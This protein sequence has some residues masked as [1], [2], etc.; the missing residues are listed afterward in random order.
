M[1]PVLG[2]V[3]TLPLEQTII[4]MATN[5]INNDF[6]KLLVSIRNPISISAAAEEVNPDPG[7]DPK[8]FATICTFKESF[9]AMTDIEIKHQLDFA[10]PD[11]EYTS[12]LTSSFYD[13]QNRCREAMEKISNNEHISYEYIDRLTEYVTVTQSVWQEADSKGWLLFDILDDDD[14]DDDFFPNSSP[15]VFPPTEPEFPT[16]LTEEGVEPNP[17]PKSTDARHNRYSAPMQLTKAEKKRLKA[18]QKAYNKMMRDAARNH[19]KFSQFQADDEH[20]AQIG[21]TPISIPMCTEEGSENEDRDPQNF[22]DVCG[23]VPCACFTKKIRDSRTW[24]FLLGAATMVGLR[25][26]VTAFLELRDQIEKNTAQI[27]IFDMF[28]S[29]STSRLVN[30]LND[31]LDSIPNAEQMTTTLREKIEEVLDMNCGM[32]PISIRNVLRALLTL[33]GLYAL[34]QMGLLAY[35]TVALIAGIALAGVQGVASMISNLDDWMRGSTAQIGEAPQTEMQM[36]E[37]LSKVLPQSVAFFFSSCVVYLL[38]KVPGRDN[39][40]ESWMRKVSM[41]PRTCSSLGE[42]FNYFNETMKKA[43]SYF[44]ITVMGCDPDIVNDAIPEI[45]AWMI[46]I[47]AYMVPSNLE[48]AC[49]VKT[50]RMQIARLYLEGHGLLLKYNDALTPEYRAA[51]QRMMIQAAKIKS[52]VEGKYPEFKA[53][54]NVPLPIWLVG[55]S[56]IGKSRLQSLIATELCLNAGLEDCKDQIYQR[57]VE[58]EYW[59]GYNN[60]FVVIMDD[61]GQM[62]DTVSAPNLEFFEII[63]S[64]GPFPYPLHMADIA[65]KSSTMFTSGV[66]MMSTNAAH[67]NIESLTYPDAVWNRLNAQSW[68]VVL[69]DEYAIMKRDR[70]G[71]EYKTLNME[72]VRRDSP[73]L[74]NGDVW[75]INPYIYDFIKFDARK[76]DVREMANGQKYGWDEFIAILKS[77]LDLRAGGGVALDKFLDN[78]IVER[79]QVAQIG[80]EDIRAM[81]IPPGSPPHTLGEFLDWMKDYKDLE[82]P[83]GLRSLMYHTYSAEERIDYDGDPYTTP[84]ISYVTTMIPDDMYQMLLIAFY[85]S[86]TEFGRKVERK[87]QFCKTVCDAKI[88]SLPQSTTEFVTCMKGFCTTVMEKL[89]AFVKSDVGKIIMLVGTGMML[90]F[91]KSYIT[92]RCEDKKDEAVAESDTRN[93]QPRLRAHAKNMARARPRVIKAEMGQSL[94]QLDVISKIR[95]QQYL[96]LG[97]YEDGTTHTFGTI[98][99]I[100]GQIFL[101]PGHF[102]TYFQHRKPVEMRMMHC[103]STKVEIVKPYNEFF[104]TIVGLDGD[105]APNDALLFSIPNFIRGKSIISHFVSKD[106]ISKLYER[107]VYVTLSG[108]DYEKNGAVVSTSVSGP[109]DLLMDKVHTYD[110]ET[111]RGNIPVTACSVAAYTLPTKA[112]DC[113]KILSANCD[114]LLGRVLGIHVSGSKS[115]FNFAQIVLKEELLDAVA[116]FPAIAQCARGMNN[117][118]E[119]E[120]TPLDTGV[121]HLG[122]LPEHLPQ[123]SRTTIVPSRMHGML[124]EPTTKPAMLRPTIVKKDGEEVLWDPLVEGA[125]KAGRTCGYVATHILD[126]AARDVLNICKTNFK[127]GGPKVEKIEYEDAIKGVEGDDLFQPIN[128]TTSPGYPY[129]TQKKMRSQKGKTNWMGKDEWEFTTEEAQQ[130]KAD[131]MKMEKDAAESN[132][133]DVIWVDTLKDERRPNEKAD[134]GNTRV[135]SNG[136]MHFN[137]LFRMYFMAALAFIRHNRIFNGVAVG[138]NV[139]DREWDHLAKWL[140]ANSKRLIDGDFKNFDG[141]LM[142]QF[143]WKIFWILDSMYDDEFHTIRYNLWYQVVYAIR[144]CRGVVYQCTHSLPS[145]FV[146]TAEVNSLFVNLVFRC[147]YLML[148]AVHCPAEC[149]MKSFNENVRLIAYGDDNVLSI[150]PKAL[151]WFNM[152]TLVKVMKLFGMEYTAADKSANIVNNKT[153]E[154]IS[155]LKRGFRMVD[156]VFGNT[157]VYL[158]PAELATRLEMLNWT[159]QRNFD[160][161]PEESDV[162]SEVIKEIAMHGKAVYDEIVPKIVNAAHKAGVTGFRDEGLYHYHHPFISGHKVPPTM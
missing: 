122:K 141:T 137:I 108:M 54:R 126:A 2:P 32:A 60:Q 62:K 9:S 131:T 73:R 102:Y 47:E 87:L 140:L 46:Q 89:K 10:Y 27:G 136:P 158:C 130:L 162:V 59:D 129:M 114:S 119:G 151:G 7:L 92:K 41:F 99:N 124:S 15:N 88:K 94:G 120:G 26:I 37:T 146:A 111:S 152:E 22:C 52:H 57:C 84:L 106:E 35:R 48:T 42:I 142:D 117:V 25:E 5:N 116:F 3:L 113:G 19:V 144:V 70:N 24:G 45:T 112:G 149:S 76:R 150:T 78:Y 29:S 155:F 145:G 161:N 101:M 12:E 75:E 11:D 115:G 4:I 61:F 6:A 95:R 132:P 69:K 100:V 40:P 64:V 66:L 71:R 43:W 98:T 14:S 90:G 135:I 21:G 38:N 157:M 55:E 80:T 51:M 36:L 93:L 74:D 128:R 125:K 109:A 44:Q 50:K 123:S 20:Y 96:L 34:H 18:E 79:K 13:L 91:L 103:D 85:K 127:E 143:M 160:S 83:M 82:E 16:D 107:K 148:A 77:D 86:E 138:I 23:K 104:G 17:G 147:A 159:K 56:Q 68:N 133:L 8:N 139:W 72:A 110:L 65:A 30:N 67:M 81:L 49:K 39:S 33:V 118:I 97:V 63:R 53:I 156:S 134:A 154:E 28:T 31:K 105:N 153:I 1:S 121:I 58:Q